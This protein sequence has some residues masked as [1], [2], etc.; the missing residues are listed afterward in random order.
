MKTPLTTQ[1]AAHILSGVLHYACAISVWIRHYRLRSNGVNMTREQG[2]PGSGF[3][4]IEA[5]RDGPVPVVRGT[6]VADM[7]RNRTGQPADEAKHPG[8]GE[9]GQTHQ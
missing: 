7:R 2:Y 1:H 8:N 4:F 3:R 6:P 9:R 5:M